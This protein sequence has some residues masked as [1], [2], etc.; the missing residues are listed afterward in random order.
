MN[1]AKSTEVTEGTRLKADGGFTCIKED[2]ILTVRKASDGCLEVPC[3]HG[4][5]GLSG[6]LDK[7]VY[8][9]FEL[10]P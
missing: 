8:V 3:S 4:G 10:V 2:S 9:G 5:H 7:G 6:Q 1:Y